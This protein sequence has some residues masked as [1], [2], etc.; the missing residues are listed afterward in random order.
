MSEHIPAGSQPHTRDR[1]VRWAIVGASNIARTWVARAIREAPAGQLTAV[2]SRDAGR[3][4]A[5]ARQFDIPAVETSLD[6]LLARPDVDAVYVSTQNDRHLEVAVAAAGSGKHV[7]C[8]KPLALELSRAVEMARLFD[9]KGLILGT[10]HHLR[11]AATHRKIRELVRSGAIGRP[12][13]ARA[14]FGEYLP[15]ELQTW[16][17][18]DVLQ[19]GVIFDLTVHNVDALRFAL[20]QDPVEVT[21]MKSSMLIGRNG[22]EDETQSIVK[23]D[24]GLL[25]YMHESQGL[26]HHE[27]ALEIHGTEGSIYGRGIMD[28]APAGQV[29]LRRKTEMSPVP[30][31]PHDLYVETVSQF[32]RAVTDGLK[33][34][35]TGWDGV[36]SLATAMAVRESAETGKRIPVRYFDGYTHR[37][38][39]S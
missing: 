36:V 28:E 31:R 22:V 3:G 17:T 14:M 2:M 5:F 4:E 11:G 29:F 1:R 32:N 39:A 12:L 8:E 24:S 37:K 9:A 10:N 35:A 23:F 18:H 19:G 13:A 6:A 20:D 27:T 26:A 7:L 21:S 16:R 30:T 15:A 33:P 38:A 34:A 25:A